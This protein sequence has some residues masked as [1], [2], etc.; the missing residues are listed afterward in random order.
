MNH[1][2]PR[3]P[4]LVE[5]FFDQAARHGDRPLLFHKADGRWHSRSWRETA[6]AVASLAAGLRA[7]G[8]QPGDRVAIVSENRPEWAIADL[9]VMAAGAISVP[10]Y[11]T[12]TPR[13]HLHI[14]EN[15]GARAAIVSTAKLAQTLVPAVLQSSLCRDV[16]ALEPIRSWPV[17]WRHLPPL[18]CAAGNPPARYRRHPR[19]RHRCARGFVLHHLH[20]RYRRRAPGR[21]L[22]PRHDPRLLRGRARHHRRRFRSLARSVPVLPAA[23]PQLRAF[24][25]AVPTADAR[26]GNL[27]RR[28]GRQ[29]RREY[30]GDQSHDHG[31]RAAPVRGD[32]RA[33]GPCNRQ[34][35][36]TRPAPARRG[37]TDRACARR[38]R[39]HRRD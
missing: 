21:M 33:D 19:R 25:G 20:Q 17:R 1:P 22:P 7:I 34:E 27:V 6:Q 15:S 13:D 2:L 10:T 37:R 23:Q 38:T 36:W 28:I 32:A 18:G 11:T 3:W 16:I 30:R 14:L 9:G 5:M 31:R 26:R 35:G 4:N 29:A 39:E 12:N 8:V 24:G